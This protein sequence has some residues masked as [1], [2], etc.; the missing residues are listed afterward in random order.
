MGL[1]GR[2]KNRVTG[3]GCQKC[4]HVDLAQRRVVQRELIARAVGDGC[5]W[6]GGRDPHSD[7]GSSINHL[8]LGRGRCRLSRFRRCGSQQLRTRVRVPRGLPQ[9]RRHD[10]SPRDVESAFLTSRFPRQLGTSICGGRLNDR[11]S[12]DRRPSIGRVVTGT[13]F[14]GG[15]RNGCLGSDVEQVRKRI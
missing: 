6:R 2:S 13:L 14:R 11:P 12:A 1:E 7:D 15:G 10:A 9:K 4:L 5:W 8:Q 3:R